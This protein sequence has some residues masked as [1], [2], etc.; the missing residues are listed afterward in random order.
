MR[1][2]VFTIL[3]LLLLSAF[4]HGM[5]GMT[6]EES[7]SH[8]ILDNYVVEYDVAPSGISFY[9]FDKLHYSVSMEKTKGSMILT[10][11]DGSAKTLAITYVQKKGSL[12]AAVDLKGVSTFK[13]K[14]SLK[15]NGEK[16]EFGFQYPDV[17]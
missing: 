3:S 10:F 16:I 7:R 9:L 1:V 11:P 5:E 8:I 2:I 15:K 6:E 4:A 12:K 13:A 17:E 14:V